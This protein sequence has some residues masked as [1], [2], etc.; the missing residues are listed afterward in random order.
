MPAIERT[1]IHVDMDAFFAAVEQRDNPALRGLPVLVGGIH[2]G[3]VAAA[4]Y[5]ARAFGIHSAMPM[6]TAMR[7]CPQ[8]VVVPGRYRAYQAVSEE[9]F[10]VFHQF[11]PL[12]EGLSLDEAF[13]DVTGSRRLFGDGAR[14]A[15]TIRARIRA[16]TGLTAS[17]G[18][19]PNKFIAKIASDFR[20]P[21]GLV[22]VPPADVQ[23]FLA[24]LPVSRIAGVGHVGEERLRR[25]GLRT[26]ADVARMPRAT[27]A[28]LLGDW[29][30]Q[31][32]ALAQGRDDRTVQPRGDNKTISGETTLADDITDPEALKP[33]LLQQALRVATRMWKVPCCG[34]VVQ[35]KLKYADFTQ[36]TR[37]QALDAPVSDPDSIYAAACALLP[38]FAIQGR[39][40]RLAGVGMSDLKPGLP[41][42][43]LFADPTQAKRL[44]IESVRAALQ[45]RF[46]ENTLTRATLLGE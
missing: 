45:E 24:P 10:A 38:R 16:R 8:A 36:A 25:V 37:R 12:V 9:V 2:R 43:M 18:V 31:V 39:G 4:S 33:V 17:A 3:V 13:L 19:A 46:G 32:Q 14:I 15:A 22:V 26:L 28:G 41:P 44:R 1:I 29:G 34:R 20:K 11:T 6:H 30:L 7:R 27:M 23:A 42:P 21:D 40:V 5:E 35:V